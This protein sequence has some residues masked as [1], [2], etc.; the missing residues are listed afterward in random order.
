[1]RVEFAEPK[2]S[3]REGD[4]RAKRRFLLIPKIIQ[5]ELRWMEWAS[6]EE[7]ATSMVRLAPGCEVKIHYTYIKWIAQRW[8]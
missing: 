6:W 1:M 7:E 8:L 4:T 3:P 2:P 5:R